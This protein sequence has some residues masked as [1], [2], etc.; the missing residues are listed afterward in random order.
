MNNK[1]DKSAKKRHVLQKYT[2]DY[3]VQYPVI[4]QSHIL[5]SCILHG[6]F[7]RHQRCS[8]QHQRRQETHSIFETYVVSEA[9]R[10]E[11]SDIVFLVPS[12]GTSVINA[13]VL[14]AEFLVEHNVAFAASEHAGPLFRWMF[15]DFDIARKYGCGCTKTACMIESLEIFI[16]KTMCLGKFDKFFCRALLYRETAIVFVQ[17]YSKSF[18]PEAFCEA[19]NAPQ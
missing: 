15:P 8:Q 14:F 4:R 5:L 11:T 2:S 16:F 12:S 1:S 9:S 6:L 3:S 19:Q 18:L 10:G 17:K 13:E 7:G